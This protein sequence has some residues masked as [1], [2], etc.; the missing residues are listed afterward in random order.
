M[1]F[2]AGQ[3]ILRRYVRA[4]RNIWVQPMRVVA[5][6]PA[7]LLLWHPVGSQYAMLI[8]EDGRSLHDV[9]LEELRHPVLTKVTWSGHDV[10][11]FMPPRS[12]YS[13]W[14]FF[15]GHRFAGWYVNLEDPYRRRAWGV[16]TADHVLDIVVGPDRRW[17]WKDEDEF[18]DRTGRVGYHDEHRAAAIRAEGE[19][20]AR[21]AEEGAFPFDGTH[22]DFRPDPSW[23]SPLHLPADWDLADREVARP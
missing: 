7:G 12:A 20:L 18:V 5:D 14:W 2:P 19:R 6:D 23:P 9:P 11:V 1:P 10:L 17:R 22:A 3:V 8:D 13:V 21:L 15:D 4:D 16:E